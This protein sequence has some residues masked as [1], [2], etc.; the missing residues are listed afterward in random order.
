MD[1]EGEKREGRE[2]AGIVN[3]LKQ[4]YGDK[5]NNKSK[6]KMLASRIAAIISVSKIVLVLIVITFVSVLIRLFNNSF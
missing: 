3:K 6:F 2:N 1:D 5:K 4:A